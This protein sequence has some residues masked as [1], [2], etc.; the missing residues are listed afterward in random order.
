MPKIIENP[1][2]IIME[3]AGKILEQQGYEALSMRAIAKSCGI[4]TGTIYNYF[5][6][7]RELLMQMMNDYWNTNFMLIDDLS[8]RGADLFVSLKKIYE[9]IEEF[10]L[11]FR[12][13][14][15]GM[16]QE[17]ESSQEAERLHHNHDYMKRLAEVV[18]ILLIKE[19]Q[20]RPEAWHYPLAT[21][22]LAFFIVQN[23]MMMCHIKHFSYSSWEQL[24]RK[25][26]K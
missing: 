25:M 12:D 6:T 3:H 10:I 19:A 7:K 13:I 15:A 9:V 11:R 1:T 22:E 14:W 8:N 4:A 26:L 17:S 5:P 24:L 2:A 21:Q 23:L 20:L 18:E 16:R